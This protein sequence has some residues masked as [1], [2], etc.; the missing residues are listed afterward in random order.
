LEKRQNS[1]KRDKSQ[2]ERQPLDEGQNPEAY[3]YCTKQKSQDEIKPHKERQIHWGRDKA[4][5]QKKW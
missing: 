2:E 4:Q 5:L 3:M 1:R